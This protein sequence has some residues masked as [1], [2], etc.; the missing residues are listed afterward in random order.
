MQPIQKVLTS[1]LWV[2][3]VV[4]MVSVIGAGLWRRGASDGSANSSGAAA[5][6]SETASDLPVLTDVPQFD[7]ID[8]DS[9]PVNLSS[10]AGKPWIADFVFTH[11]AGPCPMMTAKMAALRKE[12]PADVRFVSFSVDPEH[13]S[14]AVLKEYAAKFEGDEPRWRFVT[15]NKDTIYKVAA[16]M[17]VTAIPA[18]ADAPI[19]HDERFILVDG[20]GRMRGVY[21]SKDDEAMA[22][23]KR[24]AAALALA[25]STTTSTTAAGK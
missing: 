24:D 21:H 22:A 2:L 7:L 12:L 8:Q 23:L 18:T 20:E 11:C 3:M 14:P 13:D 1:I 5:A 17:L 25:S 6:A 15:G 19:I 9:K 4:A 16:G 10:L